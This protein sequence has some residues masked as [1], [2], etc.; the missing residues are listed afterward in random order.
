MLP[1]TENLDDFIL[2][3]EED[4]QLKTK[5]FSI[6][7]A[8]NTIGGVVDELVALVQSIYLIL[9]IES[10]QYII[11]P[12][13]YGVNTLDLIG[14][15]MHYVMA[16]LPERLKE[17]LLSDDRIT[18]V[19]DFEFE[20]KGNKLNVKFGISTIYGDYSTDINNSV[21]GHITVLPPIEISLGE[22][23]LRLDSI[24][25]TQN[26]FINGGAV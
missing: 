7:T 6:N 11:Y 10:D 26:Y 22:I 2:D 24:I 13:T 23:E 21:G 25:A 9:S 17:A 5:T 18:N 4:A 20:V 8:N 1:N 19:S 15:P 16:V 12:Y 3:F 14:K